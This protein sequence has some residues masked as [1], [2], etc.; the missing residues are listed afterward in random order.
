MNKYKCPRSFVHSHI[1][2]SESKIDKTYRTHSY[3]RIV[4]IVRKLGDCN[5]FK[6][7]SDPVFF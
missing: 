6:S 7:N 3:V 2:S 5:V 1:L 4:D